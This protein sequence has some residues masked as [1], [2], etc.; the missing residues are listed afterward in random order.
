MI[1]IAIIGILAAIGIPQYTSLVSKS[2]EGTVMGNLGTIRSALSTY[3]GDVEGIYPVD[4]GNLDSLTTGG[5]YLQGLPLIL[6]PQTAN[7][8]GHAPSNAVANLTIDDTGGFFYYN[9]G[10]TQLEW[11]QVV[12]N[13][14]H[15][16]LHGTPWSAN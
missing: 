1:T 15:Q 13:C 11:G 12:V 3:Y 5:K 6:L 8:I 14:L 7:S 9:G 2:R 16:D 4:S 10:S